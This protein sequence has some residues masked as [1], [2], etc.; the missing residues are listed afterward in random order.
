[1][2]LQFASCA[3]IISHALHVRLQINNIVM[4]SFMPHHPCHASYYTSLSAHQRHII[5]L[6]FSTC[7]TQLVQL[8]SRQRLFATSALVDSNIDFESLIVDFDFWLRWK[9]SIGTILVFFRRFWFWAPFLHLKLRNHWIGPFLILFGSFLCSKTC[10]SCFIKTSFSPIL[11]RPSML[12]FFGH[13]SLS[14]SLMHPFF[15]IFQQTSSSYVC[16]F[17]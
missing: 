16:M 11:F 7:H 12:P 6:D 17:P 5:R 14:W 3:Q 15:D 1:M 2:H 10:K 13:S 8:V 9:F 4:T